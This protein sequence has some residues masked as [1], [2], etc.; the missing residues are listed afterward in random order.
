VTS[1]TIVRRVV[2]PVGALA[3]LI[4]AAVLLRDAV[5]GGLGPNPIETITH[6]TGLTALTLLLVTLAVSPARTI[7]KIGAI[8]Q[9]RRMLGLFA[10]F[11][12]SLHFLTYVLD[13][14]ILSGLGLSPSAIAE[15]IA[16]R[17]YITVG[18]T[19]FVLLVPLAVTSTNRMV[20][21]LGGKRWQRLHRLVYVSVAGG[22]LHFL[23]QV[24]IDERLPVVYGVVLVGLLAFR[25][26]AERERARR[27]L[28]ASG[29]PPARP[30]E[31]R[32]A[33]PVAADG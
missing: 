21:R 12:A 19:A 15:D 18:F 6:R 28:A 30:I 4:P 25:L 7:L 3:A 8:V 32:S 9:L 1:G 14:T 27:R 2:K 17:P 26:M 20:R 33:S 23:W 5:A 29:S 13:Q 31:A 11:Y 10:F 16:K 22:V 24:K